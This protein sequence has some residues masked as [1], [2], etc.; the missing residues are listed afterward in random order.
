M[1]AINSLPSRSRPPKSSKS[2]ETNYGGSDL[3]YW[4]NITGLFTEKANPKKLCDEGHAILEE[5][6]TMWGPKKQ[7]GYKFNNPNLDVKVKA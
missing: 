2:D 6:S 3:A 1:V 4:T 7:N 5:V